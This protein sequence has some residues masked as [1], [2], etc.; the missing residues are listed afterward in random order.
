MSAIRGLA[1]AATQAGR[2]VADLGGY[3]VRS[4]RWWIALL[5]PVLT[6]AAVVVATVKVAVPSVV[7]A[8][9]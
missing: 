4:G 7:Y 8:F 6:V 9:F 5:I 3:M 1:S 2:A